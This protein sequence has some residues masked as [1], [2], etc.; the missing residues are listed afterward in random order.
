MNRKKILAVTVACAL[1]IGVIALAA[2]RRSFGHSTSSSARM[3]P[4]AFV[5]PHVPRNVVLRQ[6]ARMIERNVRE[7]LGDRSVIT[8]VR[9]VTHRKEIEAVIGGTGPAFE[10]GGPAWIV[11][12][13]GLFR[14]ITVPPGG[15][16]T[17][18]LRSG[19]F[20]IDDVTGRT[21]AYGFD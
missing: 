10:H 2:S 17:E 6:D 11:R 20:V 13:R 16:F 21:L 4:A 1:I 19:Y 14:P 18:R 8:S 5:R 7:N 15:H 9:V 3:P 12:A